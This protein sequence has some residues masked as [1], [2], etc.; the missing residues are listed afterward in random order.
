MNMINELDSF[1]DFDVLLENLTKALNDKSIFKWKIPQDFNALYEALFT[2]ASDEQTLRVIATLGR[3]E[4]AVKKPLFDLNKVS[5]LLAVVPDM[6]ILKEGDDRYYAARFIIRLSPDWIDSWAMANVWA[7]PGAE[8]A[9]LVFMETLIENATCFESMLV[10][11]GKAGQSYIKAKQL[12]EPKAVARC[13]RVI[14]ALRVTC[15][16]RDINCSVDVGKAIDVFIGDPF[17]HFTRSQIKPNSRKNLVPEVV[18]LLLDLVGQRF[19]LAI[20]SEHYT[21]LQRLRKWCDDEAWRSISKKH[22]S[23]EKLS[24]TISQAL[25][26]LARQDIADGEL[27]KRLRDSVDSDYQFKDRCHRISETGQLDQVIAAW[28]LAGGAR[29]QI[30]KTISSEGAVAAKGDTAV[31]GD[32]LLRVQE[33]GVAVQVA[34]EALDDLELFDP[35]LLPVIKDLANHW[36]I[37]SEIAKKMASKRSV[38][39]MGKLGAKVDIDRKLFDVVDDSK[40]NRRYGTVIRS[41]VVMT[42]GGKTQVIKKGVV[43]ILEE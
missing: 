36:T 40:V 20:E 16:A 10:E 41:A 29:Q 27:L 42:I 3:V 13:L 9:R 2:L 28:I 21:A 6:V 8:K 1:V 31:L 26:I 23:L 43:K 7:E 25:L 4:A 17:S 35:S 15:Q 12:S 39:L 19:S 22:S 24:N 11:L 33:G 37:V 14:K 5:S 32:L 30:K 38:N 18:G 34:E